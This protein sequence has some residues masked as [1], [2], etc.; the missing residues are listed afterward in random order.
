MFAAA[1]VAA[2]AQDYSDIERFGRNDAQGSARTQAMGGAYGALG[3]DVVSGIVNPAGVGVYRASEVGVSLGVNT[4][5][6]NSSTWQSFGSNVDGIGDTRVNLYQLGLVFNSSRIRQE[7]GVVANTFSI[8]YNKIAD[9]DNSYTLHAKNSKNSLLDFFLAEESAQNPYEADLAWDA[10]MLF[11]HYEY[12]EQRFDENGNPVFDA[13]HNEVWDHHRV[14]VLHS[15]W[16]FPLEN[17]DKTEICFDPVYRGS[18]IDISR[19]F[20]DKGGKNSL[21]MSYAQNVA[22]KLFWGAGV[23]FQWYSFDR[24]FT[25]YEYF[26]REAQYGAP[27][28]FR[29]IYSLSQKAFGAAFSAGVIYA[30]IPALRLG[31]AVHSPTFFSVNERYDSNFRA[32]DEK[33]M[34]PE[35]PFE[36]DY[37]VTAPARGVFSVAGIL[38]RLGIISADYELVGYKSSKF[39][40][41]DSVDD[42]DFEK[43][44]QYLKEDLRN[45]HKVR[46]GAEVKPINILALRAGYKFQTSPYAEGVMYND[47]LN[48]D[49]SGGFGVRISNFYLDFSYVNHKTVEDAYI[50]PYSS[51]YYYADAP[52]P[53]KLEN[54]AH[55]VTVTVGCR[56]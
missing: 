51:D 33:V 44:N 13:D 25:H 36:C 19:H 47:Y 29:Y 49:I 2:M 53:Y 15:A 8:A 28:Y 45:V 55:R 31:M 48:R 35:S 5:K 7:S 27:N 22:N 54:V 46:L 16:D 37:H 21:N 56:F 12:D 1:S 42:I 10:E 41:D 14:N 4:T 50:L 32:G 34:Y 26:D 23:D 3:A 11:D 52:A 6:A 9:F 30:P 17:D 38:G 39:R 40:S 24:D 20:R 18:L 43:M